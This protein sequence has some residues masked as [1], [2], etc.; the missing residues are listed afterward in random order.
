LHDGTPT[1]GPRITITNP[2]IRAIQ[3]AKAALYSGAR[4]LMDKFGVDVVDR[5]VLAG[6]FGAHISPKH[7]MVLGMIP[8]APLD[9]VTSAGNAAGTGARIALLNREARGEIEE[10]VRRIH[11]VET[12]IEPRFQEHFVNASALPNS[13]DPFPILRSVV[14]LPD[15]SF[16]T[17]GGED[18]GRRR[19]RRA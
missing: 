14:D 12:A 9:K 16:N 7:A 17:G 4:L 8:D 11:K 6:A 3:M 1:G 19:R 10:T 2:D 18:G 13:A 5:V 15:V